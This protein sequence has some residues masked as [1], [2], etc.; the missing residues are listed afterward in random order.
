[1]WGSVLGV[2]VAKGNFRSPE[3]DNQI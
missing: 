3:D 1:M 2:V